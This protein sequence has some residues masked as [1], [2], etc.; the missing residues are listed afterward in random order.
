[1]GEAFHLS[2]SSQ[3]HLLHPYATEMT[4]L[5]SL[6]CSN[7]NNEYSMECQGNVLQAS[8]EPPDILN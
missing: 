4:F 2:P 7:L 5:E 8:V 3:D 1:M 6:P